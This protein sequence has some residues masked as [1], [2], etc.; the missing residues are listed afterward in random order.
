M[1][2]TIIHTFTCGSP[3][4]FSGCMFYVYTY[5]SV[6]IYTCRRKNPDMWHGACTYMP[7]RTHTYAMT[8]SICVPWLNDKHADERGFQTY[9]WHDAFT[10]IPLRIHTFAVTQSICVPWLNQYV[11]HD[12]FDMCA[13]TQCGDERI[14]DIRLTWCIHIYAMTNS[15]VCH[16]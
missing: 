11:C 15:Y 7:W 2:R 16:D 12:W 10:Y 8:R 5:I 6:G 4:F 9:V 3:F 1:A 14:P 13:M